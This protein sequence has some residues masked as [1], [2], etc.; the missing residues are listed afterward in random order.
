M[1]RSGQLF[2]AIAFFFSVQVVIGLIAAGDSYPK[3]AGAMN[4]T[5]IILGVLII[6]LAIRLINKRQGYDPHRRRFQWSR[7][8]I[9]LAAMLLALTAATFVFNLIGIN[10]NQQPNQQSIEGLVTLFPFAMIF[11]LLIVSPIIEEIVFRELLPYAIGPS[12][13]SFIASSLIFMAL[14]APFGVMGWT[15]YGILSVGFLY[16]RLKDNNLYTAIA[17][18]IAWNTI[19]LLL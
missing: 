18:H 12:I 4:L 6:T 3:M 7:V 10:M 15:S 5:A 2:Q 17:V 8:V 13:L 9:I 19:T 1:F 14:H 11:T 16:A